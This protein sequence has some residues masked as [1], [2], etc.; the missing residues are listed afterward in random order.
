MIKKLMLWTFAFMLLSSFAFAVDL[1]N[2]LI[3]CYSLDEDDS[4]IIDL[5][6]GYDGTLVGAEHLSSGCV[7]GNCYDFENTAGDSGTATD[8]IYADFGNLPNG[9][10]SYT[11]ASWVDFDV[12]TVHQGYLSYG[13]F[14]ANYN[15]TNVFQIRNSPNLGNYYGTWNWVDLTP[16]TIDHWMLIFNNY[17]TNF[18][19]FAYN[20]SMW[21][22][23]VSD[24]M[25]IRT[26][27]YLGIGVRVPEVSADWNYAL[28]GQMDEVMI[29]NRTLNNSERIYLYN[30]GSGRACSDIVTVGAVNFAPVVTAVEI[31]STTNL[32]YESE[33]LDLFCTITDSDNATI[34][35]NATYFID[36]VNSGSYAN[37]SATA[38]TKTHLGQIGNAEISTDNLVM[39]S[40]LGYDG[41][42]WSTPLNTS[43]TIKQATP[44]VNN[45]EYIIG[46]ENITVNVDTADYTNLSIFVDI[47]N[48]TNTS[49]LQ[50]STAIITGLNQSTQ[51]TLNISACNIIGNCNNSEYYIFNTKTILNV[52]AFELI[53]RK[54]ITGFTTVLNVTYGDGDTESITKTTINNDTILSFIIGSNTLYGNY[55]ILGNIT[56]TATNYLNSIFTEIS[57]NSIETKLFNSTGLYS[58]I[59]NISCIDSDNNFIQ[60]FNI[61]ITSNNYDYEIYNTTIE[62]TTNWTAFYVVNTSL[63]VTAQ[64]EGYGNRNLEITPAGEDYL[65]YN[66]TML[67]GGYAQFYFY[68]ELT[69]AL[70]DYATIFLDVISSMDSQN[71]STTTGITAVNLSPTTYTFRYRADGYPERFYYANIIYDM[72]YTFNLYLLENTSATDVIITLYDQNNNKVEGYTIKLLKYDIVT[73]SY[74]LRDQEKTDSQGEAIVQAVLFTEFYKFLV[75]DDDGTTRLLTNPAYITATEITLQVNTGDDGAEDFFNTEAVSHS[76]TFNDATNNFR[77]TYSDLNGIISQSCLKVYRLTITNS[78]VLLNTSCLNTTAGT[79]LVDVNNITGY[80]YKADAYIYYGSEDYFIDSLI[81]KFN[82]VNPL[83]TGEGAFI[84]IILVVFAAFVGIFSLPVAVV[85]VPSVLILAAIIG[86]IEINIGLLFSLLVIGIVV[87]VLIQR[88][89]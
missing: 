38:G 60:S 72:S 89:G 70:M 88:R 36:G 84:T 4:T 61:T 53:T 3:R 17:D 39:L 32:Y 50:N 30:S 85:L 62:N 74:I 42:N 80:S 45:I 76:L 48:N 19:R 69:G 31:N 75:A 68:N 6:G 13:K 49:F 18:H 11:V 34:T 51:Y 9:S 63:N 22:N 55:E 82:A 12:N 26:G 58:T 46:L 5:K 7:V 59:L 77:Y 37:A 81:H 20:N 2:G 47:Y 27:D 56:T 35:Y 8:Y 43:V 54:N 66:I 41:V 15:T 65:P 87:A 57:I 79:I 44:S 28:N 71:V 21:I 73:N 24:N 67:L 1:E 64:S 33:D 10:N 78:S 52:S 14:V 86:F 25:N 40:C 16:I 83:K 29:W 23:N